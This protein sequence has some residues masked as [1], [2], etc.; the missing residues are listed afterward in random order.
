M[1]KHGTAK[2]HVEEL[3][4]RLEDTG[5]GYDLHKQA[6]MSKWGITH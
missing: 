6:L 5:E 4:R 3:Q 1:P 2:A